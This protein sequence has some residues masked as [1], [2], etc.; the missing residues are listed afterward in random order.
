MVTQPDQGLLGVGERNAAAR[1]SRRLRREIG[2]A[3]PA[4]VGALIWARRGELRRVAKRGKNQYRRT[5]QAQEVHPGDHQ[6]QLSV[7]RHD[8]KLSARLSAGEEGMGGELPRDR[9]APTGRATAAQGPSPPPAR[10]HH[11][12]SWR[13]HRRQ[14]LRCEPREAAGS[15]AARR[16]R[17]SGN[18]PGI[19]YGG[20][21][22]PLAFQVE[23][24]LLRNTLA[25]AGAV[26]ELSI[27][28]D[29]ATPVVVKEIARHPVTGAM[30][31]IDLLRV[32]LDQAISATV[33]LDLVGG[34]DSPG[35]KEG[36]VLEQVTRELTIEALPTDIPDAIHL[37][38][39]GLVIGDT[40]TLEAVT[41]P[42]GV[43]L[44]DDPETVVATLSAP[45]LQ[46]EEEPGIEEETELV[47]DGEAA[48]EAEEADGEDAGGE[49]EGGDKGE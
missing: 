4:A 16:L 24:R 48:A 45:R 42:S 35:V 39:S 30:V 38:V 11:S 7:A 5:N 26:L 20:G 28:G 49:S 25:H 15:R 18:V 17:R 9:A 33:V 32:R 23:A 40:V 21:E 43:T 1:R 44:L 19:L 6:H 8:V 12:P 46:L 29:A 47:A 31:H 37:D 22:E 27:G 36:G 14:R 41:P 34:D 3:T 10:Y 13:R 2:P